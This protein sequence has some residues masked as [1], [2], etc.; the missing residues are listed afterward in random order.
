MAGSKKPPISAKK[1][2]LFFEAEIGSARSQWAFARENG[3]I[4]DID[5]IY[6]LKLRERKINFLPSIC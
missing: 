5:N 2:N 6:L 1:E 3:E 4:G